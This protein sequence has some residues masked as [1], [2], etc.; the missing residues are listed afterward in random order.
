MDQVFKWLVEMTNDIGNGIKFVAWGQSWSLFF[1]VSK[2][3]EKDS[4]TAFTMKR[5]AS[6]SE[7]K[8]AD[9]AHEVYDK[10]RSITRV[11]CSL[12]RR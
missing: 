12:L 8:F 1:E 6:F 3:L 7:T 2:H 10:F 4:E 5:P 9:H 11:W